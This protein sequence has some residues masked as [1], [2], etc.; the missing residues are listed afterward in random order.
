[1]LV[2]VQTKTKPH[3]HCN[4]KAVFF[5]YSVLFFFQMNDVNREK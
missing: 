3:Q 1:M 2:L 4:I 5:V